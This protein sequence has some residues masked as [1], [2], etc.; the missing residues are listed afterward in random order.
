METLQSLITLIVD[1]RMQLP[2]CWLVPIIHLQFGECKQMG[3]EMGVSVGLAT[4][5]CQLKAFTDYADS[6]MCKKFETCEIGLDSWLQ[7]KTA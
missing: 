5:E 4:Q 2:Y 6:L 1:G 7:Q 3:S